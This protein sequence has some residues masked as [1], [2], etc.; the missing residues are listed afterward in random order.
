MISVVLA[1]RD[2]EMDLAHAL[3][4]L[5][6]AATAG[7][8][9]EAIVVDRGSC[10]GTLAVADAAGCRIVEAP[11]GDESDLRRAAAEARADWL[12]FLSPSAVL[13]GGWEADA[14]AFIDR[15]LVA[16]KGRS[17][18]ALFTL[19][20]VEAGFSAR[21]SEALA[22]FRSRFLAAPYEEQGLLISSALY[23]E[24]GGHRAIPG[25]AYVDLI[26]RVGRSRLTMLRTRAMVSASST[27]KRGVGRAIRNGAGL[28]LFLLHLPPRLIVR[29]TG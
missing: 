29:L 27:E 5:V 20:R 6:P 17:R 7:L 28:A 22:G 13:E 21:F 9:R 3:A 8:V 1:T 19:G 24:I 12:L 15:A 16:G 26:R 18:A 14:L 4:A 23:R 10:D 2:D 25:M 11:D